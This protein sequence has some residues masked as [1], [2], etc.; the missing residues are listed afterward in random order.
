MFTLDDFCVPI[1]IPRTKSPKTVQITPIILAL[2]HT[3]DIALRDSR[4]RSRSSLLPPQHTAF[5]LQF[6]GRKVIK[7]DIEVLEEHIARSNA[8]TGPLN[9]LA[10]EIEVESR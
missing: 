5:Y 9:S 1:V 10:L 3:S 2:F 4:W 8:K 7:N 6:Q